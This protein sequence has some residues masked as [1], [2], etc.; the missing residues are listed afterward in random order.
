VDKE[1][2]IEDWI[3]VDLNV[4]RESGRLDDALHE[5]ANT[6]GATAFVHIDLQQL[7]GMGALVQVSR[8][9]LIVAP[10]LRDMDLRTLRYLAAQGNEHALRALRYR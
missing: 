4:L 9:D 2:T 10:V 8:P 3:F 1:M 5:I 7:D 6:D